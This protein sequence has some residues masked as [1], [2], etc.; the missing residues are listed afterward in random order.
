MNRPLWTWAAACGASLALA[1]CRCGSPER[2]GE[3]RPAAATTLDRPAVLATI[4]DAAPA[5]EREFFFGERGG[6]VA[7]AES[8]G[9][10]QQVVH[11]GR[12]GKKYAAVGTIALSPDGRRC[13]HGALAGGTW[14]MVVDGAEGQGFAE[15]QSPVFSPD[16]L[17]LAY[18]AKAGGQWHL[19]V[20]GTVSGGTRT[21]YLGH[22]FSGDSTR[23][24]FID[25]A[26]DQERGRLVVSDL[27]FK[28][29]AVVGA[30]TSGLLV[31]PDRTRLAVV[32]ESGGKQRVLT[33]AF[34]RPVQVERGPSYD[35]VSRLA[36]GPD[37]SSLAYLAE[38]AGQVLV[39]LDGQEEPVRPGE[40]F[41]PLVV[42]PDRKAV[43]VF[44]LD[45]G[46][47]RL[48]QF[49]LPS[50]PGDHGLGGAESLVY[51]A[52]GQAHAYAGNRGER[53]FVVAGEK[54]G[55]PFDR[56]V[57][58][59]F[60]PDGKFIVYRARKDGKRFVVVAD[61]SGQTIHQHPTYEQ[62]FPV[63]F[64]ADG[65]AVAYGVKDGPRLRWVV[66]PL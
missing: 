26:D 54:E 24:A 9:G 6:G 8:Q 2:A 12:A 19:V 65:K 11:N 63:R 16:G 52:D 7:W 49:F 34:D 32:G 45:G 18:Q 25:E 47:V 35:A 15:V 1:G 46:T 61:P 5:T 31:N 17:H 28:A 10:S 40:L 14:H 56:V 51:S 36:F 38:R 66:E 4:P 3:A 13:A 22:E 29:P 55:P 23:I 59:S 50:G 27:A 60:S 64:T 57:S 44:A 43:G 48:Q 37:G 39:V 30:N 62:V 20:D 33:C 42:S 41:G 58:P 53:W 21:R